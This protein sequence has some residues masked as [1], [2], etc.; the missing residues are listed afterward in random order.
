MG[1][2]TGDCQTWSLMDQEAG[3]RAFHP[4]GCFTSDRG[5]FFA[6]G[7]SQIIEVIGPG[8]LPRTPYSQ[9]EVQHAVIARGDA[10][11]Q[12]LLKPYEI[13]NA[14]I[15]GT[16]RKVPVRNTGRYVIVR[17]RIVWQYIG[18]NREKIHVAIIGCVRRQLQ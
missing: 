7:Y 8:T 5:P 13:L 3:S 16:F 1:V 9:N 2:R 6:Y 10:L 11:G 12:A 17:R 18:Q 15:M 14:A 4:T